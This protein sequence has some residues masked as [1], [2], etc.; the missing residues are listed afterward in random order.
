[1]IKNNK[2]MVL[3]ATYNG[4]KFIKEQLD[5]IF[6]QVDVETTLLVRDDGSTDDT[7]DILTKYAERRSII[8]IKSQK[9]DLHGPMNNYYALIKFAQD[10]YANLFDYFA[11]AD[12]D[13]VWRLDKLSTM[14]KQIPDLHTPQLAYCNHEIIDENGDV[15]IPSVNEQIGLLPENNEALLYTNSFAWGHSIVFNSKLLSEICMSKLVCSSNFPHD[16]YFAKFAVLTHGIKFVP[17]VLVSYRRY[18]NNVSQMWY[19]LSFSQIQSYIKHESIIYANV[20]NTTLMTCRENQYCPFVDKSLLLQTMNN[21]NRGG[22]KVLV[23]FFRNKI[24]RQQFSRTISLYLV[25]GIKIYKH[26][27]GKASKI[28]TN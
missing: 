3:M 18:K 25:Y 9:N 2:V 17:N 13:D 8:I 22:I 7:M 14:I 20:V 21:I 15:L 28:M 12:Q 24:K 11:F 26:Y 27:I 4:T 6:D 10:N 19:R 16:A 23:Y 5:S 1:M